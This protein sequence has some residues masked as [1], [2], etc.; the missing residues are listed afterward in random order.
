MAKK[1]KWCA[2]RTVERPYTRKSKY[3]KKDY[4]GAS[5][6]IKVVRFD[7]GN[8]KV[9]D[10]EWGYQLLLIPKVDMQV[11]DTAIES[12]RQL[13]NKHYETKIG[14]DNYHFR[15]RTY[16]HHMLRENPLAAG[17][18]ADRMSTGMQKSFGKV[19]GVA[20]RVKTGRAIF[21]VLVNKEKLD[22]A[23]EG[24]D[25][26]RKKMPGTYTITV[27]AVEN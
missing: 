5:P 17:A 2:Y 3:R 18:G 4:V 6:A 25:M 13:T 22:L 20:A 11:R 14:T 26:A 27:A 21:E 8:L 9:R 23:K 24:L 7:M 1:R 16:P 10:N 15:L 12:A 19:I